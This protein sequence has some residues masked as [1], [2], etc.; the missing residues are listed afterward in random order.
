MFVVQRRKD[1]PDCRFANFAP[2][3]VFLNPNR[4]HDFGERLKLLDPVED[5]E[6]KCDTD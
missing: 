2:D 5:K 4:S 1:T 3:G 6:I